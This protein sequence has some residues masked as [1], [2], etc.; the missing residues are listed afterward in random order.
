MTC[1]IKHWIIRK[2]DFSWI[3]CCDYASGY[4]TEKWRTGANTK[5][6]SYR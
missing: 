6:R 1:E 2:S 3:N 5:S 4:I